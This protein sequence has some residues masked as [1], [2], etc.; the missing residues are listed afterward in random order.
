MVEFL[1]ALW[2]FLYQIVSC[3]RPLHALLILLQFRIMLFYVNFHFSYWMNW[4]NSYW[5]CFMSASI[6]IIRCL[7]KMHANFC[8]MSTSIAVKWCVDQLYINFVL[9]QLPLQFLDMMV[10]FWLALW[11]FF[12]CQLRFQ[13]RDG[14]ISFIST[15]FHV[16][17]HCMLCECYL[18]SYPLCFM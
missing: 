17:V 9:C 16:N 8:F 18:N 2:R 6:A 4:W 15:L 12:L 1:L 13:L 10:K 3:Q 14:S 5:F 11:W 7:D